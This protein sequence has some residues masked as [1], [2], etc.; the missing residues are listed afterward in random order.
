M[1]VETF[2]SILRKSKIIST[3]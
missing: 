1:E 2:Q 3:C